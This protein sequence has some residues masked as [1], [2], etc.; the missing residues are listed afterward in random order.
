MWLE[1]HYWKHCLLS[2]TQNWTNSIQHIRSTLLVRQNAKLVLPQTPIEEISLLQKLTGLFFFDQFCFCKILEKIFHIFWN[3]R[4]Y[5]Y[6][7]FFLDWELIPMGATQVGEFIEIG[8]KK[9]SPTHILGTFG[10]LSLCH[11]KTL[12]TLIL[13][14][15]FFN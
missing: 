8:H 6:L 14:S 11:S 15:L 7:A 3:N 2:L 10:C 13:L 5:N 4:K 9:N 12:F 1:T